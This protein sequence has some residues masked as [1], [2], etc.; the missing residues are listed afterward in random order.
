MLFV[1][2][3]PTYYTLF[4]QGGF[5]M[6]DIFI[7]KVLGDKVSI[8][9]RGSDTK[10]HYHYYFRLFGKTYRGTC[11]SNNIDESELYSIIKYNDTKKNKGVV[12][13]S[14]TFRECVN[15]FFEDKSTYLK[16]TS[17]QMY[18]NHSKLLLL[19]FKKIDP[20][21]ITTESFKSY[22][23]WRRTYFIDNPKENIIRYMRLGVKSKMTLKP[24]SVGDTTINR[25]IGLLR[26]ILKHNMD[27]DKLTLKKVPVYK[28]KY[29]PPRTDYLVKD[30]YLKLKE[31][32]LI[33]N[34]N[35]Y[36][37]KIIS[38]V[39]NTG[40]RYPSELN[41]LKWNDYHEDKD[42]M[43][44]RNRKG[45][46]NNDKIWSIPIVGTS[47]KILMDLKNRENIKTEPSD[48]IFID[49]TGKRILNISRSF[50]KSIRECGIDKRLSM[51]SL[52]HTY[53]TRIISTRPDIPLKILSES[54]GHTSVSMIEKH[55]GHLR[56]IDLVKYFQK[57]ENKKQEIIKERK[58]Q[59]K[60]QTNTDTQP[61]DITLDL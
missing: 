35:P 58:I 44:I 14:I 57:S 21:I 30:E 52:R 26:N 56:P 17:L 6:G 38:F 28:N 43:I 53:T 10:F 45:R 32:Y 41:E 48:Y 40:L 33:T 1:Q 22:E 18:K 47:K 49:D 46:K 9:K 5:F 36:Y 25:E 39:Q 29:E 20:N 16:T 60:K 13:K 37:W 8:Y 12:K 54:L 55:Y 31:Y 23:K 59:K 61:P 4:T 34:P 11:H 50:K 42:F 24:H 7:K 27:N 3:V 15:N 19:Y 51:Y 2:S